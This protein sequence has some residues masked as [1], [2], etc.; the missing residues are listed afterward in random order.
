MSGPTL[1]VGRRSPFVPI[2]AWI[3]ILSGGWGGVRLLFTVVSHPTWY[4][5][6]ALL[7]CGATVATS[8]GLRSRREW[9]RQ[10]FIA[11]ATYYSVLVVI[12]YLRIQARLNALTAAERMLFLVI[13]GFLLVLNLSIICELR[14]SRVRE[15]FDA[16][17]AV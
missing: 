6:L 15:E 7:S 17:S 2:L 16:K 5:L 11:L 9:A 3:G 4:A 13:G 1:P 10:G 8:L 14:S 12:G